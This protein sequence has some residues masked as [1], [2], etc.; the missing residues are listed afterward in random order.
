M[1]YNDFE[2][3]ASAILHET[4]LKPP[5]TWTVTE[6]LKKG[7][8][9]R[10]RRLFRANTAISNHQNAPLKL[11][12]NCLDAVVSD[13][14]SDDDTDDEEEEVLIEEHVVFSPVFE[15]PVLY[16]RVTING[17]I[18]KPEESGILRPS[19]FLEPENS[20]FVQDHPHT[21][22]LFH[23]LHPCRTKDFMGSISNSPK[24]FLRIWLCIALTTLSCTVDLQPSCANAPI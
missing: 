10:T 5:F 24:D 21:G 9:R 2:S 18:M 16:F 19:P 20:L 14:C 1:L 8:L 4:Q 7:Y 22:H 13:E 6:H 15:V 3:Q 12:K 23:F 11:E 17:V